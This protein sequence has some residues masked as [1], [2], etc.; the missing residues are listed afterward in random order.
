[1]IP[2]RGEICAIADAVRLRTD[3][4]AAE[5]GRLA[6]S[7]RHANQSRRLLSLAAVVDGMNR[8]EAARRAG[9]TKQATASVT[10]ERSA[11]RSRLILLSRRYL[12]RRCRTACRS[13]IADYRGYP[14][15]ASTSTSHAPDLQTSQRNLHGIFVSNWQRRH[16]ERR[17]LGAVLLFPLTP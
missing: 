9:W 11:L 7:S 15:S 1:M 10:H 8:A 17:S 4:S 13:S 5:L 16:S 6:S 3:Y 14:R 2:W 12:F